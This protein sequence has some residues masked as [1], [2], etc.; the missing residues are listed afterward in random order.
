MKKR[1]LPLTALRTFDVV[2]ECESFKLAAEELGVTPTA[3]SH[4]IKQLENTLGMAVIDRRSRQIKLTHSGEILKAATSNAFDVLE[5]S[6][7][8]IKKGKQDITI[9]STSNFLSNWLLPRLERLKK[10]HYDIPL[11]LEATDQL[12]DLTQG[13]ADIAIRYTREIN[14]PDLDYTLIFNDELVLVA[15]KEHR[16]TSF[17]D[18]SSFP[19]IHVDGRSSLSHSTEWEQWQALCGTINFEQTNNVHFTEESHAIQA[20]ISGSGLCIVSHLMVKDAIRKGLLY[21]PFKQRLPG[22]NYYF[23]TTKEA[24]SQNKINRLRDWFVSSLSL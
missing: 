4:Q 2:S 11:K 5:Q 15:A 21:E 20:T 22:A 18:L 24:A 13:K 14:Q 9:S 16:I 8:K 10:A 1:S 19:L 3:V 7:Y 6:I 17:K 23:V 12:V